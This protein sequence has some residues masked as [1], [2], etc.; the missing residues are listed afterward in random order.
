MGK[1]RSWQQDRHGGDAGFGEQL[2]AAERAD[3]RG[4]PDCGRG[5]QSADGES[6]AENHAAAQ[7]AHAGD[8]LG[9]HPRRFR[10]AIECAG[11]EHVEGR[12]AT[13]QGVGPQS[14]RVLSP[15][16]LQP[17]EQSQA[18]SG[19]QGNK[20]IGDCHVLDDSYGLGSRQAAII[21]GSMSKKVIF[22]CSAN[23]Y[24]SRYAE[25]YFNWL[26]GQE[27]LGWEA[28]SRG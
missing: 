4:T 6:L 17:D 3:G 11:H 1:A 10:A 15:L 9:R 27:K 23:Y 12:P 18:Q 16:P 26:A 20:K 19:V 7:K 14:G 21:I 25:H 5:R 22:V 2:D 24:R 28:D 8:H 13:D